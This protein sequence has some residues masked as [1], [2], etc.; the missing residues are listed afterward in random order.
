MKYLNS[1]VDY[2]SIDFNAE[3]QTTYGPLGYFFMGIW[4]G[5]E[6]LFVWD[7]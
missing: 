6:K 2:A 1:Q 5:V 3:K 7:S 4:W